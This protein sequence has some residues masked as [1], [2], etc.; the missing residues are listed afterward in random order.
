MSYACVVLNS[1]SNCF[2]VSSDY[3]YKSKSN[4]YADGFTERVIF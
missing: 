2:D 3:G 1:L 4:Y